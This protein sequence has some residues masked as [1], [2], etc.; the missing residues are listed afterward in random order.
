MAYQQIENCSFLEALTIVFLTLEAKT[1]FG[2]HNNTSGRYLLK[3][4]YGVGPGRM[5][6]DE[7]CEIAGE[8]MPAI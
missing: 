2:A 6:G 1:Q 8:R 5:Q 4:A 7:D 3:W